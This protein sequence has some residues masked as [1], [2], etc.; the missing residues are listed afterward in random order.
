MKELLKFEAEW[1][2]Q[3]KALKPTLNNVLKD[4]P[5]VKLT[6]VDCEVEEQKTLKY[7]IRSMPTLIYLVDGVEIGRLSGAVPANKIVELLNGNL[8]VK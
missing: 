4:F 5:D 2:S 8:L 3:C 6:I 7:Q 1:C